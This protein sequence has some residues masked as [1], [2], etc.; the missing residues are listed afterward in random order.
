MAHMKLNT[1]LSALTDHV[2]SLFPFILGIKVSLSRV[3]VLVW[4]WLG[5]FWGVLVFVVFFGFGG[6][7]VSFLC[8]MMVLEWFRGSGIDLHGVVSRTAS[9]SV[10]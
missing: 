5:F 2:K 8:V 4:F 9:V 1:M 7:F 10:F 3:F 6:L